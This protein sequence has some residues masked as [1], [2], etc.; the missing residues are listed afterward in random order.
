MRY[1]KLNFSEEEIGGFL[2]DLVAHAKIVHP[3][4]R[5]DAVR[6]DPDDDRLL[7][8]GLAAGANC[9]VTG[10]QHL[11]DLGAYGGIPILTSIQALSR[12]ELD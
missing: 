9:L 10:D 11:L 5:I 8:C 4:E 3:V 7:E 1:P 2:H 12:L 6:K